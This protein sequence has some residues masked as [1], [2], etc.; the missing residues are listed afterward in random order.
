M[1]EKGYEKNFLNYHVENRIAEWSVEK[2][3]KL[4]FHHPE[5]GSPTW[6]N[7]GNFSYENGTTY[8]TKHEYPMS[9]ADA[10]V[11][12][13]PNTKNIRTDSLEKQMELSR[14]LGK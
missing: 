7:L 12:P 8:R 13:Q 10:H 1:G 5:R 6:A 9:W 14:K 3:A 2:V 11:S 4:Q